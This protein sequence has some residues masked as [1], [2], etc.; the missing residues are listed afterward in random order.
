[1][2]AVAL[3]TACGARLQ[4]AASWGTLGGGQAG[5]GGNVEEP[6]LAAGSTSVP[7][8]VVLSSTGAAGGCGG[9]GDDPCITTTLVSDEAV[10]R[11]SKNMLL[12][13]KPVD[14]VRERWIWSVAVT[15]ECGT[16][17]LPMGASEDKI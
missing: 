3:E 16:C 8:A 7:P 14:E 4:L 1:M 17:A 11:Y 9:G 12:D 15:E 5:C 2:L 10:T 13:R 6:A